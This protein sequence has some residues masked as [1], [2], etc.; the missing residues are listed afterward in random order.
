MSD[1]LAMYPKFVGDMMSKD[2]L[3]DIAEVYYD[4]PLNVRDYISDLRKTKRAV[5]GLVN[6]AGELNGLVHKA[7]YRGHEIPAAYLLDEAGDV[8]FYIQAFCNAMHITLDELA[9][10][11]VIKLTIRYPNGYDMS[12]D[13]ERSDE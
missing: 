4:V 9:E 2:R 12:V 11:N 3:K 7:V 1:I 6:E 5:S 10:L 8:M 13:K